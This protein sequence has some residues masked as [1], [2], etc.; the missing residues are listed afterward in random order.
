MKKFFDW[1]YGIYPGS[2]PA[3]VAAIVSAHIVFGAIAVCLMIA[4][5]LRWWT[6]PVVSGVAIALVWR[7]YRKRDTE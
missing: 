6:V 1:V 2:A 7:E 3:W 4:V 5:V